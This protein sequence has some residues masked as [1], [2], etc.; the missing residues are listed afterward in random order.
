MKGHNGRRLKEDTEDGEGNRHR[1]KPPACGKK[2]RRLRLAVSK[3]DQYLTAFCNVGPDFF[4]LH[5]FVSWTKEWSALCI[6]AH[7]SG[8]FY[9][10]ISL[11]ICLSVASGRICRK[12]PNIR[13]KDS[14]GVRSH[15]QAFLPHKASGVFS[16]DQP[17][18]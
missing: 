2:R 9:Y 8:N 11:A 17:Q 16:N 3:P 7:R 1:S 13:W 6:R 10:P 4:S 12:C 14:S 18:P 5:S 15:W